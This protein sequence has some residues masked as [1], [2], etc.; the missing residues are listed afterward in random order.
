[1]KNVTN[2]KFAIVA[3]PDGESG[4]LEKRLKEIL[5]K[6]GMIYDEEHPEIV[7][8]IGGDGTFIYAIHKYID[9][10]SDLYFYGICSGTLGFFAEYNADEFDTFVDVFLKGEVKDTVFPLLRAE[11]DGVKH[12]GL[13]EIRIENPARTQILDIYI[14]DEKLETFHGSGMNVCTQLGSSAYNRSLGGA[15]IQEGLDL[16]EMCEIAGIHHS[17]FHSLYAPFILKGDTVITFAS[18]SFEGAVMGIDAAVIPL[19]GNSPIEIR[20]SRTKRVH[21]LKGRQITYI[22]RLHTLF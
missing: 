6:E 13:N 16:I 18:Q 2:R 22:D 4:H 20:V 7:F 17:K 5:L 12:Y 10:V 9:V 11:M 21:M 1:M 3:R 15:V 14:N 19:Y 8:P